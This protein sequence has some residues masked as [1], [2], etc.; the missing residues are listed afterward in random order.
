MGSLHAF[1]V[2]LKST[3]ISSRLPESL[4]KAKQ[5]PF[6]SPILESI[7][8]TLLPMLDSC[9]LVVF[10]SIPPL[11]LNK[12]AMLSMLI[13]HLKQSKSALYTS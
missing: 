2:S 8:V 9:V 6:I 10:Y 3:P 5:T 7:I 12:G 4:T 1:H 11:I 13:Q